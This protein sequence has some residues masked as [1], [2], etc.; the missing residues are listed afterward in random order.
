MI[1]QPQNPLLVIPLSSS[2][3][4]EEQFSLRMFYFSVIVAESSRRGV[5]SSR[6]LNKCLIKTRGSENIR[7]EE[8]GSTSTNCKNM[9]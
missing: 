2:S 1:G 8:N 6:K 3:T 7:K 9:V 4:E 5:P